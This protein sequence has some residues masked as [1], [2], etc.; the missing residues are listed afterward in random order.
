[1]KEVKNVASTPSDDPYVTALFKNISDNRHVMSVGRGETIFSQGDH[2]DSIYFI[3]SGSVKISV[4]S[5][6]GKEG[7]LAILGPHSFFGEEFLAAQSLRTNTATAMEPST[8]FQVEKRAMVRALHAQSDL[9]EVFM[10]FLLKR[11]INLEE[12]LADQ[13]FNHCE[14]RLARVLLKLAQLGEHGA[15]PDIT[16]AKLSHET[17]AE[18]VGTTRSRITHFMNKFRK[19]H[20]IEY[21]GDS[22]DRGFGVIVRTERLTDVVLQD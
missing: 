22:C 7:V 15:V 5:Y 14:K 18:M 20:L 8:V 10:A 13:L 1:M 9:A 12:D 3:Q 2:A 16:I 6:A 19:M 21:G 17:L 11:S 4:L